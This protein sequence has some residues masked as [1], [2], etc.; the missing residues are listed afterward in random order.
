MEISL[1]NVDIPFIILYASITFFI[2]KYLIQYL[3]LKNLHAGK[4]ILLNKLWIGVIIFLFFGFLFGIKLN[5][6]NFPPILM[7]SI[8]VFFINIIESPNVKNIFWLLGP[9]TVFQFLSLFGNLVNAQVGGFFNGISQFLVLWIIGF[10]FY[11]Y[12]QNKKEVALKKKNEEEKQRLE[13][14]NISLE[15]IV[16]TRTFEI[17]QQKEALEKSVEELKATQDQLIQSEKMASLGELTAGIAHEIQNPLNFVNNFSD[18]SKELL[19][20]FKEESA[21]PEGERDEKAQRDIIDDIIQNLDKIS[22]HGK[23]ASSIVKNMLGHSR[24]TSGE[25]ELT[26]INQLC[27]EYIRLSYHGLRAKDKSFNA[28][29]KIDLDPNLP[30]LTVATQDLGRVILNLCNNAFYAVSDKAISL[31][32]QTSI[33]YHPMVIISTKT[34]EKNISITVS[35]NGA[36]IPENIK[37]KIFQPFFTTKPTG[38]G[39]GLGLSLVYD[40]ITK[41]H[42][43]N[44]RLETSP[45]NG[46][47]FIIDLPVSEK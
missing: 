13:K 20:E 22:H 29:F 4:Y 9:Y 34:A 39:T 12:R 45:E 10:G 36:G 14:Q 42:N 24:T 46:T 18:I 19:E 38:Q 37:D 44:I 5:G 7:A 6:A 31:K 16:A 43:G 26:D 28:D 25:K 47:T 40:I 1:S 2:S 32:D 23:R 8:L 35:D 3:D 15:K 21:K 41:L 17:N 33:E 11:L 30:Q 27:D